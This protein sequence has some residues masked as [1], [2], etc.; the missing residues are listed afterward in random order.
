MIFRF[1]FGFAV[2][3][4]RLA[5]GCDRSAPPMVGTRI[6]CPLDGQALLEVEDAT[7]TGAGMVGL[8]SKADARSYF[9]DLTVTP[10]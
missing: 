4:A 9:D 10:Q 1:G 8:W 2:G 7:F 6:T 5:S 3:F